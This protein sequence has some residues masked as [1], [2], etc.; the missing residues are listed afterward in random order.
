V[1]NEVLL[2]SLHMQDYSCLCSGYKLCHP[3]WPKIGF[4]HF[5]LWR[6]KV[7][8]IMGDK[9]GFCSHVRYTCGASLVT[10]GQWECTCEYFSVM[11]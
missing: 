4:L 10:V 9:V 7:G 6:R 3:G 1:R 8:Q 5:D 11:T 2:V